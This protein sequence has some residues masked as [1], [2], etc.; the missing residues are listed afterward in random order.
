[1]E[2]DKL[3]P[4]VDFVLDFFRSRYI[5]FFVGNILSLTIQH[6]K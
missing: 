6:L 1:M 3:R 5:Y 4:T 2:V